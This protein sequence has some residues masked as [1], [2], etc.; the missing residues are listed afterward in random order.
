MLKAFA[1]GCSALTGVEAIANSVPPF[2]VPRVRRAQ[3]TEIALGVM[4]GVMLLGLA[5]LIRRWNVRPAVRDDGARPAHRGRDRA[6]DA[7]FYV[8]QL[9]TL[10]LLALAANTSFGG[11]PVLAE[12]AGQRQLPAALFALRADRQVFR[13]GVGVLA[14][15]AALLLVVARGDTQALVPLFA[16]GVFVGFTLSQV[17]MVRHWHAASSG[18]PAYRA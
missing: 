3:H 6:Q 4:L 14:V 11:L 1:S 16:V 18:G 7:L 12:P 5:V 2:R 13:Y 9:I 15:A 17:G 8:I 10:V